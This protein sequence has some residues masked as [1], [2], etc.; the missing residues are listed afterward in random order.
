M[1]SFLVSG[2]GMVGISLMSVLLQDL[3]DR[4]EDL[5]LLERL[6]LDLVEPPRVNE[7]FRAEDHQQLPQVHLGNEDA[8]EV[9]QHAPQVPRERIQIAKVDMGDGSALGLP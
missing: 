3:I 6:P 7:V 8:L 2:A 9:R 4:G 1:K 5:G